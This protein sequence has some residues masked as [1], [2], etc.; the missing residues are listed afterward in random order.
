MRTIR[1]RRSSCCGPLRSAS[2]CSAWTGSRSCWDGA[3][4][5]LADEL[6]QDGYATAGFAGNY[7]NLGR[8]TGLAKGF[9]HYEDYP[10]EAIQLLRSTSLC[11][12][13]LRMDRVKELLGRRRNLAE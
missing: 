2:A 1:S 4:P 13:L 6:R 12:R 7:L 9:D 3:W 8:G 10:L 5:T 11:F